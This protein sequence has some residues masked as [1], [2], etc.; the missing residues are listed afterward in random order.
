MTQIYVITGVLA[1]ALV[2]MLVEWLRP[3]RAWPKVQGWL[4]RALIFNGLQIAS[5]FL[6]GRV[7]DGWLRKHSL[8][9]INVNSWW[10]SG[11]F[12]YF[13]ITFVFYWWHRARHKI[14]FLWRWLHQLHHSPQ[15][16]EIITSFYKHPLELVS[17]SLISSAI[18]YL[19]LGLSPWAAGFAVL[20][21]G[22]AELVYHWNVDTPFWLGYLI[23]RPESHCVHHQQGV[24]A[25]NYGDLPIWDMLF[26]TYL[27]PRRPVAIDVGFGEAQAARLGTMLLM[28]DVET[29]SNDDG[30]T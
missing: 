2:M 14:P 23:Q 22:M 30:R 3:G 10:L 13:V 11:L 18:V 15:R 29:G 5:V 28:R 6:A 27:N 21:S 12:G 17:N 7:W 20:L 16:I 24:H 19:L 9:D 1:V 26:G 25:W 8:M 4:L